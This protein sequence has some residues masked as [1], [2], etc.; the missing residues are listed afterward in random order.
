MPTGHPTCL[1]KV[2]STSCQQWALLCIAASCGLRP[3][4]WPPTTGVE[5]E[6]D[7][8]LIQ[9]YPLLSQERQEWWNMHT[10]QLTASLWPALSGLQ[11]L[12]EHLC[13]SAKKVPGKQ[14]QARAKPPAGCSA[15]WLSPEALVQLCCTSWW[16]GHLRGESGTV[17]LAVKVGQVHSIENMQGLLHQGHTHCLSCSVYHRTWLAAASKHLSWSSVQL[18][19]PC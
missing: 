4:C 18:Q 9:S 17:P 8:T 1:G 16:A 13:L 14:V 10:P 2:Q 11:E 3:L 12:K 6:K 19:K 5:R 7:Q 15:L